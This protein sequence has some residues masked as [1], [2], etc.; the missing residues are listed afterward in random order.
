MVGVISIGKDGCHLTG[1]YRG[2]ML[3]S[4]EGKMVIE[5]KQTIAGKG[6]WDFIIILECI[7]T[8]KY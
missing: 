2:T 5:D 6:L 4:Y 7:G 1:P 3:S 8:F